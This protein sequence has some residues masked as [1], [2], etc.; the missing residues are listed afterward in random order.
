MRAKGIDISFWQG[1]YDASVKPV[2]FIIQR[3]S[4]GIWKD[5]RYDAMLP[6][7][8]KVELRGAY[9]YYR[10]EYDPILQAEFF[11][12]AQGNQGFKFLAVDYEKKWNKLDSLAE[13]R[14]RIF[15]QH[16]KTLTP[17]PLLLYTSPYIYKDNLRIYSS[18]WRTVPLWMAHHNG[19]NP[20][21]GS[22]LLFDA[23][24]WILWQYSSE[25]PGEDYGVETEFIDMNVYNG[26]VAQMREWLDIGEEPVEDIRAKT[27]QECINALKDLR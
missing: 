8:R 2:D 19:L 15:W 25:G 6:D 10:T 27:I 18:F 20:E 11:H 22:P 13:T 16:L 21:N 4:D 9:H 3:C 5:S 24:E 26:T 14:L 1:N 12:N 17:K 7:V 23:L